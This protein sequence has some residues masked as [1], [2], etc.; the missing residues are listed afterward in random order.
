MFGDK[1][2][3]ELKLILQLPVEKAMKYG[4]LKT[5]PHESKNLSGIKDS[6]SS[7][8]FGSLCMV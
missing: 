2:Y 8:N 5:L 1:L 7:H 4:G 6:G 3:M